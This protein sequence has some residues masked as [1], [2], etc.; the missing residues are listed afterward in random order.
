MKNQLPHYQ[1][2]LSQN[3]PKDLKAVSHVIGGDD[4]SKEPNAVMIAYNAY[5]ERE[6]QAIQNYLNSWRIS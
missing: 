4:G 6:R 2:G 1:N 5:Q 3:L